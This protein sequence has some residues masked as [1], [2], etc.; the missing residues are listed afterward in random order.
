MTIAEIS[1]GRVIVN[2]F[3]TASLNRGYGPTFGSM[4]HRWAVGDFT[5]AGAALARRTERE[6]ARDLAGNPNQGPLP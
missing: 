2:E 6:I 1:M 4:S 3:R 5:D